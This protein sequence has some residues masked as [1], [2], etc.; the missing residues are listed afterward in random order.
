MAA[1]NGKSIALNFGAD[2]P[3]GSSEATV[4]G[5]A[6]V[7]G[8]VNWNNLSFASGFPGDDP[9]VIDVG[10][11]P[12][13]S[14]VTVEWTSSNT[15]AT[16]GRGEDTNNA[17]EGNDRALM[18][19]YLD[20]TS[21]SISQVMVE[22]IP[23]DLAAGYDVFI[24]IQNGVLNRGG[25]YTVTDASGVHEQMNRTTTIFDGSY[26]IGEEGNYL[27]YPGLR[28]SSLMIEAQATTTAL[29]R[30]PINAV[31]IC[32]ANACTALPNSVAGR[33]TIGSQSI[34]GRRE[35]AVFGPVADSGPGL[36]Q[37]WFAAGNPGAKEAI[38]DIFNNNEPVI[39]AFRGA[40]GTWW[41]GSNAEF[42]GLLKYPIEIEPPLENN[43]S[44]RL[45]GEINIPETGTYRFA[46]GVDDYTYLAID[47]NKSGVAGDAANEVLIDDN[48]WTSALRDQNNGGQGWAEVDLSVAANGE[49]LAIE[50]NAAEG[51]GGDSGIMYWDYN[52]SAPAGSRLGGGVGFPE[53]VTDPV[54]IDDAPALLIPDSHLRSSVR[55]LISADLK[56]S[57][58]NSPS[59]WQFDVNATT[60]ESDAFVVNNPDPNVYDTAVD[61]S[62]TNFIISPVGNV[63]EGTSFRII[64]ADE[65]TGS[66][67]VFPPTWTFN[68]ATGFVTFGAAPVLGDFN[69]NGVLDAAD[70]DALSAEVRTG[71]N[72]ARF[73]LTGD[74]LVNGADR[75][76]WVNVQ[77]RTYYGDSNLDG[78]FN[79]SDLVNVFVAGQYEDAAV[80]NSTWATGDWNGD[81]E[82][83]S[84]DF[85]TAF[86]AGGYEIGPRPPVNAVP[87]QSSLLAV[88]IGVT[89]V[90]RRRR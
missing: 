58:P 29:F 44:V 80:N 5:A 81:G 46:D 63:P 18:L 68:S 56:A 87:E 1:N 60:G 9:I 50:V 79:S 26:R 19:G 77:R 38:D 74:N 17:P 57:L 16:D 61:V 25:T 69:G 78:E 53:T 12:T 20:T 64:V 82:F 55:P 48:S 52:P 2:E 14:N 10:A 32:A 73:D 88:L 35:N 59:G 76:N 75:D 39:P 31:E 41:T 89:L 42:G 43:Y 40:N 6:G 15:W 23:A 71:N 85:V 45:T 47:R 90:V 27:L 49:W 67:T 3:S 4:N 83:N 62:G 30:A 36:A 28:G 51:G 7:A 33:G 70:I 8:T 21:T 24:Y 13:A 11:Q 37:E 66:P 54:N 34:N 22:D 84:S 72:T 86:T 65:I